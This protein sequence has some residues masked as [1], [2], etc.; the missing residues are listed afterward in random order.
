[1]PM[2]IKFSGH[3]DGIPS[4]PATGARRSFLP[5][6]GVGLLPILVMLGVG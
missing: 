4:T 1:M 3:G 2:L 5:L 6:L